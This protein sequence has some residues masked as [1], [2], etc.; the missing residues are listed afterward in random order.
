[1]KIDTST[2]LTTQDVQ[3]RLIHSGDSRNLSV[4][5]YESYQGTIDYEGETLEQCQEEMVGV[6]DGKY[7]YFLDSASFLVE[8][9]HGIKSASIVTLYN[10]KPLLAFSMTRPDAQG[11]GLAKSLIRR[12]IE[13]LSKE[14]HPELYL[15]V[16]EGNYAA[17]KLYQRMG[18]I[19]AP[20]ST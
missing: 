16:T 6:L 11:K 13:T 19:K 3:C 12:S 2:A 17:E 7:G 4:L 18:F 1:M 10:N 20:P 9:S 14:G 8:D 15:V 5:M